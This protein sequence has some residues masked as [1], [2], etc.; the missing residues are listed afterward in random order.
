MIT[1]SKNLCL[2][3]H[4]DLFYL[5]VD[6]IWHSF[7]VCWV[8]FFQVV[9]PYLS[10]SLDVLFILFVFSDKFILNVQHQPYVL[11]TNGCGDYSRVWREALFSNLRGFQLH[12]PS[13]KGTKLLLQVIKAVINQNHQLLHRHLLR[14][15]EFSL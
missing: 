12:R 4:S 14:I 13:S 7:V 3:S 5:A 1:T 11:T 2:L 9:S 6:I 10:H 15:N 8:N